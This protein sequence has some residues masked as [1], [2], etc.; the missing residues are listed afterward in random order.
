MKKRR[1]ASGDAD[2]PHRDA[3]SSWI[4]CRRD[5][6]RETYFLKIE[7]RRDHHYHY[8]TECYAPW[9]VYHVGSFSSQWFY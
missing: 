8:D 2:V 1:R 3:S 7:T 4:L 5:M 6:Y 9:S